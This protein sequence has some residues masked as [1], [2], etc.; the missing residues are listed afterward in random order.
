[1]AN[2]KLAEKRNTG[3]APVEA[4]AN[5]VR[6][7]TYDAPKTPAPVREEKQELPENTTRD[8]VREEMPKAADEVKKRI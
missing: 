2:D 8:K 3:A 4:E 7:K 5:H 6:E 1:M